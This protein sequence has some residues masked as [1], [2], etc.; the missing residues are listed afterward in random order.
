MADKILF[1][2]RLDMRLMLLPKDQLS[3]EQ[4]DQLHS[5]LQHSIQIEGECGPVRAWYDYQ[6]YLYAFVLVDSQ[7]PIAI[8]EASGR[9]GWWIDADFRGLG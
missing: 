3:L 7:L 1:G 9:P 6:R 2:T 4:L 5:R 8:A